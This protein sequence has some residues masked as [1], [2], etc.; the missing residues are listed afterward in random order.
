MGMM[1]LSLDSHVLIAIGMMHL[2]LGLARAQC[3][4]YDAP[5]LDSHVLIAMGVY[6]PQ[7]L[8]LHVL[9]EWDMMQL[10]N[11]LYTQN[12]REFE[13]SWAHL[14]FDPD[15]PAFR[16]ARLNS[17]FVNVEGRSCTRR[18]RGAAHLALAPWPPPRRGAWSL[19]SPSPRAGL[20]RAVG[21]GV[22]HRG[23]VRGVLGVSARVARD[24]ESASAAAAAAG[25]PAAVHRVRLVVVRVRLLQHLLHRDE[26]RDEQR[27]QRQQE[28]LLG[29]EAD[30]QD[31]GGVLFSFMISNC[32]RAN[33][34]DLYSQRRFITSV[35][36]R[37][38]G[39]FPAIITTERERGRERE[40]ETEKWEGERVNK[41]VNSDSVIW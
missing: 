8:T 24:V 29:Q 37:N 6:A 22:A 38:G 32:I 1:N 33:F 36:I 11:K 27:E 30:A 35:N 21:D 41:R 5:V 28:G 20:V 2:S 14:G 39:N 17:V 7:Y 15:L 40:G 26:A 3:N 16:T 9:I 18:A 23:R 25:P 13:V 4:G 19:R 31:F 12:E 34:E 10:D